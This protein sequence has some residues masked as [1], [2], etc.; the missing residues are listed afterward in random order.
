MDQVP[1]D[2]ASLKFLAFIFLSIIIAKALIQT[3]H[4]G[5]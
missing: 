3:S 5:Y 2:S 1:R 4:M